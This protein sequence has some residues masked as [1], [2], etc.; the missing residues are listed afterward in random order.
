MVKR[1][2]KGIAEFEEARSDVASVRYQ[3]YLTA[4]VERWREY[5][6]QLAPTGK[7]PDPLYHDEYHRRCRRRWRLAAENLP[8]DFGGDNKRW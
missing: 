1:P 7:K 4:G 3:A 5:R 8:T 6:E 2:V